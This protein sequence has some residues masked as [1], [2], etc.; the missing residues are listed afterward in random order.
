MRTSI[1]RTSWG[2][3]RRRNVD[4]PRAV[5]VEGG[6]APAQDRD[7]QL[8]VVPVAAG[9][10]GVG[11]VVT[12]PEHP[13]GVGRTGGEGGGAVRGRDRLGGRYHREGARRVCEVDDRHAEVG[14]EA[15]QNHPLRV[16]ERGR[17]VRGAGQRVGGDGL[18]VATQA[19]ISSAPRAP[20]ASVPSTLVPKPS[21]K[22]PMCARHRWPPC[23]SPHV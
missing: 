11:V 12:V 16:V 21:A 17:E 15:G 3:H 9:G 7:E 2:R 13:P 5:V 14:S 20:P 6:A 8:E 23:G 10:C 4:E 22:A 19:T 18:E 1:A